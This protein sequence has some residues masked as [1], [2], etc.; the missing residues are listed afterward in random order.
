MTSTLGARKH[1][2]SVR[3]D[4]MCVNDGSVH[5]DY[6]CVNDGSVYHDYMCVNDGSVYHD[7]MWK[8]ER[9]SPTEPKEVG[10]KDFFS[11]RRR[12]P[13]ASETD[14]PQQETQTS[15]HK[16]EVAITCEITKPQNVKLK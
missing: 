16:V 1:D 11:K 8:S 10:K 4:Y 7:Y 15:V 5:H 2:G 12:H 13:S 3:H 9:S 14:N 6:M